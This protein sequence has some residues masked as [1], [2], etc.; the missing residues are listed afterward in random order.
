[1]SWAVLGCTS[2]SGPPNGQEHVV[3][4]MD[5]ELEPEAID[6]GS[7]QLGESGEQALTL[8][9]RGTS[10]VLLAELRLSDQDTLRVTGFGSP[11]I[12]AGT[13]EQLTVTWTPS[14][15][16]DL[17]RGALD[18][19]VGTQL[20]ALSDLVVPLAGTV[21]GPHL[22]LSETSGHLG[23]VAVGCTSTLEIIATNDGTEALDIYRLTLTDDQEFSVEDTTGAPLVLPVRIEPGSSTPIDVVYTPRDEHSV[24][25]TLQITS[26]DA[27]APMSTV[28][29]EGTGVIEGSNRIEWTVEGQQ[30]VTAIIQINQNVLASLRSRVDE[31]AS[32]LFEALLDADV[33]YRLAI[34]V[35]ADGLPLGDN[36]YIDDSFTLEEAVEA[37]DAMLDADPGD[38]DAGLQTCLTAIEANDWLFDDTLWEESK[39]NLMV[40]NFD[41]EQS[42]GNAEHY[43]ESYEDYKALPNLAVHGI[44]GEVPSGCNRG[45]A[46][47]SPSQNLW[48][49][50]ELTDGVFISYC[51]SDWAASVPE[52]VDGF[53]GTIETFVLT[54]NPAPWSIEVRVDGVQMF[55]GWTY[56][57]KTKEI[58]FDA[59]SYPERGSELRVD[60]LMAVS[61]P[62]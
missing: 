7:V 57:E 17:E 62:E 20:D 6:F 46:Y 45:G 5:L 9:N 10:D 53:T 41:V 1:M 37:A 2:P 38:N 29:V 49:A 19:R 33:S 47:A 12:R 39:L 16:G 21:S 43:I 58:V 14:E 8:R 60:Y 4:E 25:T 50:V 44:A 61:C 59:A 11:K 56:D 31:F 42:P 18:L 51:D 27:L 15:T 40:I 23:S 13:E 54:D 34:V 35:N 3:G 22:T 30:A 48:D 36:E 55:D 52:L 28:D 32:D 26:N 24:S